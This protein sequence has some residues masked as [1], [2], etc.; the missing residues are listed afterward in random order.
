MHEDSTGSNFILDDNTK[1][2]DEES[3]TR[4]AR[5]K[6]FSYAVIFPLI[7]LDSPLQKSYWNTYHCCEILIREGEKITGSYCKNRWCTVCNRIR[8]A[9]LINTYK[10]VLDSWGDKWFVTLTIPN[11]PADK[12]RTAIADMEVEFRRIKDKF[13]K[14]HYRKQGDKLVGFRKLE[15]T[16]N[17][18]RDDYHPHYHIIVRGEDVARGLLDEW[19]KRYPGARDIAQDVRPA[20]NDSVMELFKY[21]TK[22]I[23]KVNRD[24][25]QVYIEP[26]DMIFRAI[27][28]KRTFQN[29]GFTAP[30]EVEKPD[31]EAMELA[32]EIEQEV[33]RESYQWHQDYHDWI[34]CQTG[35]VLTGYVPSP[36]FRKLVEGIGDKRSP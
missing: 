16:Y 10:P 21:F 32:D 6:Y 26:L 25:R 29:F 3:L 18:E 15:C 19:L 7:D 5:A 28:G 14:R 27:R 9:V 35:E 4:R 8:T 24:D 20:D 13:Y 23:V 30:K 12:L 34:G 33:I 17:P 1:I 36:K 2:K 31:D 11:V 22:L